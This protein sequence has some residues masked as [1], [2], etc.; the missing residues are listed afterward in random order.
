MIKWEASL[1]KLDDLS[2]VLSIFEDESLDSSHRE[3]ELS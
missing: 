2:K 3:I 1:I